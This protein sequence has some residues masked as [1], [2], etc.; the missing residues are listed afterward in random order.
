MGD[1][2][3]LDGSLDEFL[4]AY[5]DILGLVKPHMSFVERLRLSL[6]SPLLRAEFRPKLLVCTEEPKSGGRLVTHDL[7][8]MKE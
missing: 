3:T 1:R 8:G 4:H 2:A 5:P 7:V 6:S